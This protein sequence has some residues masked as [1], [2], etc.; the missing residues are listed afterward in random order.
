MISCCH[1]AVSLDCSIV[2][3]PWFT[4]IIWH[5]LFSSSYFFLL[6]LPLVHQLPL[7]LYP[8]PAP[9][10]RLWLSRSPGY[11]NCS[12]KVQ[13]QVN[14]PGS[15]EFSTVS[16]SPCQ[17]WLC[18]IIFSAQTSSIC[19]LW[20]EADILSALSR[21]PDLIPYVQAACHHQPSRS[22]FQKTCNSS[23]FNI[24]LIK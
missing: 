7:C 12:C 20:S 4:S 5:S 21:F 15:Q 14:C 18:W 23:R 11:K 17:G 19:S 10:P 6:L 22:T 13:Q 2:E 24:D 1:A 9:P 8:S 16:G 3:A